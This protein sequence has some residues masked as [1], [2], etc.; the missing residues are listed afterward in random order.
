MTGR[1][2]GAATGEWLIATRTAGLDPDQPL[3]PIRP[4]T[5]RMK[6]PSIAEG[7]DRNNRHPKGGSTHRSA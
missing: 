6:A 2:P 5:R 7:I 3:T 1:L 4:L